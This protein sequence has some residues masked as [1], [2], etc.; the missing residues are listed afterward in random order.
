MKKVTVAEAAKRMGKSPQFVRIC[1]Q[2][3]LLPIGVATK[4]A[5]KNYNYYISPKLLD[6]YIGKEQD[7]ERKAETFFENDLFGKIRFVEKDGKQFAVASDVAKSLGYKNSRKAI[8]D[9]C[10]RVEKGWCND[11]VHRRIEVNIISEGDI[12]RLVARSELPQAE[13]FESWIFDEVLPT[14]RKHGIYITDEAY[15]EYITNKP[16]FEARLKE[17]HEE[18]QTLRLEN[19][20]LEQANEL[21]TKTINDNNARWMNCTNEIKEF[22]DVQLIY[23]KSAKSRKADVYN[24]Y[25]RW[26]RKT[27]QEPREAKVFYEEL[28]NWRVNGKPI[29]DD[30]NYYKNIEVRK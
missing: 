29:V 13:K 2:R 15:Q 21:L 9:H 8:N 6:E 11:S 19:E 18:I 1:L 12:Y 20:E 7:D 17:A 23:N 24:A 14:I 5:E 22:V 16:K 3:G 28:P 25:C 30:G 10:R 27:G 26:Y 4:T